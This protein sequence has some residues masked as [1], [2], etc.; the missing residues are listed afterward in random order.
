MQVNKP[1]WM[2]WVVAL[3]STMCLGV[4]MGIGVSVGLA[5]VLVIYRS[6]FPRIGE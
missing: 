4:Q 3:L 2:V 5:L 6:A 1:D